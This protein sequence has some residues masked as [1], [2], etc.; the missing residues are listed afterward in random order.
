MFKYPNNWIFQTAAKSLPNLET[1]DFFPKFG[2]KVDMSGQAV[3]CPNFISTPISAKLPNIQIYCIHVHTLD[4]Q[5]QQTI[6]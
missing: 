1:C 5:S 4:G 2:R 3:F 6:C